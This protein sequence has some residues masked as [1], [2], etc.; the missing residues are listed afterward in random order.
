MANWLN[1]DEEVI[2]TLRQENEKFRDDE[3]DHEDLAK[4]LAKLNKRKNLLPEEALAVKKLHKEK[5]ILKDSL[6]RMIRQ[7]KTKKG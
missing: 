3:K 6:A 5:L 7:F 2:K 1:N 4:Q